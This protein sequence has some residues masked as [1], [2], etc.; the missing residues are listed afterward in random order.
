MG[1]TS[2][3]P[4]PY[5]PFENDL[6][7]AGGIIFAIGAVFELAFLIHYIAVAPAFKSWIGWMFVLRSISFLFAGVAILAARI[8]GPGYAWRPY[9]TLTLFLLVMLSA[10]V[11]YATFLFERYRKIHDDRTPRQI[12]HDWVRRAFGLAVVRSR[13]DRAEADEPRLRIVKDSA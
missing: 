4:S 8:F 9:L 11:T 6:L 3:P 7:N 13:D 2:M 5:T 12:M 10:M 1:P